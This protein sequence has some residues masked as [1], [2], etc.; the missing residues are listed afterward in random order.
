MPS[1]IIQF[2]GTQEGEGVFFYLAEPKGAGMPALV[3]LV[4]SPDDAAFKSL[5]AEPLKLK[6]VE[7]AGLALF[8]QLQAHE[9][10]KKHLEDV[11]GDTAAD[12]RPIGFQV[13]APRA[14]SLPWEV[15][16]PRS[17]EFISLDKRWPVVRLLAPGNN[18]VKQSYEFTPP[19]RIAAV[20][21]AWGAN[22]TQQVSA[23][24]EWESL[25]KSILKNGAACPT[26]V[27]IM[28]CEPALKQL[29]DAANYPNVQTELIT[30]QNQMSLRLKNF[31]AHILHFFCHGHSGNRSH[32][33]VATALDY[34]KPADGSIFLLPGDLSQDI[35]GDQT[36]WLVVLNCCDSA[37]AQNCGET[38][39]L[40][41]SLV[42]SGFPA[43]I[44]MREPVD[45][46][47]ARLLTE[48]LYTE[49]L[50]MMQALP[51][52]AMTPFQWASLLVTGRK[53]LRNDSAPQE[54][55]ENAAASTKYWAI[56]AVYM[57]T[58]DVNMRKSSPK[59][60][61]VERQRI[62]GFL[63][64]LREQRAAVVPMSAPPEIKQQMLDAFDKRIREEEQKL[65]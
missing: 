17:G 16:C 49:L 41:A 61:E 4:A 15:L 62:V 59:L 10:I 54:A 32:L 23:Q 26:N 7:D 36:A 55:G 39:S 64:G 46:N 48:E 52:G 33:R 47:Y 27:L 44:G 6:A 18:K 19:L 9:G 58:V 43:V 37:N 11:F 21:S 8:K 31:K 42:K 20:L 24:D 5:A 35:D 13:D 12:I 60:S 53:R 25:E 38:R 45:S 65:L 14:D 1:T 40:A 51:D 28:V 57:R 30:G 63:A 22:A 2:L 3:P 56:P 34:A 50:P 29:I